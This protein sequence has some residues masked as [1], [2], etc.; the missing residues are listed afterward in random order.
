MT[1]KILQENGTFCPFPDRTSRYV[2]I[3]KQQEASFWTTEI[4]LSQDVND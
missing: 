1:E 2:E 4:D 3:Y